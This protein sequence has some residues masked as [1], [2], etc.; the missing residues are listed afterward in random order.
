MVIKFVKEWTV[1]RRI[2]FALIPVLACVSALPAG[3]KKAKNYTNSIGMKFVCIEPGAFQM[4]QLKRLAPEVLPV[5]EGGDRGGRFDLLANGDFDERPVHT[6]KIT[7]PFYMGSFE[8]TNFQYELFDPEH[9]L[10]RGKQGFSNDDD[11]AV[12][13]VSWYDAQAFCR[14]LSDQEGLLYRL[15]TEAEWEYAC[16]AGTKTNYH[17]GDILPKEFHKNAGRVGLPRQVSLLVGQTTPN[18][19]GLYDMHGNVEEWCYDWYGPYMKKRQ[20]NPVGYASGDFRVTRGGSH[21]TYAYY[22]RSANRLGTLPED[23]H[24]LIGFRVVIGKMPKT[25]PLPLPPVPLYHRNVIKRDPAKVSKGPNPDK[26]YFKGPRKFVK[27]PRSAIGPVFAGHNH[28]PAIVECPNGDLL[29]CWY[30]C[31]S[32]K[33]RE[34][35]VGGSRLRYGQEEWEPASPFWDAPDRNDHAPVLWYDGRGTIYHFQPF[36]AGATYATLAVAMRTS[37]DSGATWSRPRI[38]LPEHS[39]PKGTR[40]GQQL[41]EPVFRMNDGAIAITTDGLP[42][43]WIS[44]DEGLTWKGCGGNIN[45]NH[46]GVTQLADGRLIGFLRDREVTA[47]EVITTYEDMGKIFTHKTRKRRMAKAISEDGGKTWTHLT[48]PFP[49]IGGGQR[50]VLMRL[51]G[52]DLFLASFA[53]RGIIITDSSGAKREVRGMFAALSEDGGKTWPYVRLV[54]DDGSGTPAMTTNGG[55]FAMSARN[56]EYRGYMSGCQGLDG[57]I[58]LVSSYS[59]YS[60]N[61]AWLKTAPPPL[62]YPPVRVKRAVETFTGPKDFDLDGWEPYHGHSGGFNGK[63]RYIMVSKSH[64]QGMNRLIGADSFEMN[65]AFENIYFNPRGDTASPGIT[66]W[67]KD[68]MMR[69]LHFYVRDD[70]L[71][72]GLADEEEPAKL[73]WPRDNVRYSKPPT[74]AKLKFIYDENRKQV[75]IFYGLNGDEAA[76]EFPHSKAGIYFGKPLTESTAA[77][78]MMSNGNVD[79]DY[80]EIKPINP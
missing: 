24:W 38:I 67:I 4:G 30:M 63:G 36:S 77:Y 1:K 62:R 41:S 49:G 23:K 44:H 10:L 70:R 72:L 69:R 54:S 61:L 12:I 52:G 64:F 74:S 9:K 11:E 75:R 58:H 5:I 53:D 46:P 27:I 51:R 14:W 16:R 39:N 47:E 35:A 43:L 66:I 21:S 17:T 25:K 76:T 68:A 8:V 33:D 65:M 79:L 6:V 37:A 71:S 3:E 50:L 40:G 42:T 48:S 60:F 22:L 57:V 32:E 78:I 2:V 80:F 73:N 19:W 45:G 59:H 56:A 55:Y 13:Y 18:S 20:K 15:P 34:L 26:P 28:N 7:K 29:A 31:I